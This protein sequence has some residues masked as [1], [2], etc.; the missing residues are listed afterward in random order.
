[1]DMVMAQVSVEVFRV[2]KR[3]DLDRMSLKV[4][5][6]RHHLNVWDV[7]LTASGSSQGPFPAS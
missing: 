1:M 7:P 2:S 4:M 5:W 3:V 6:I